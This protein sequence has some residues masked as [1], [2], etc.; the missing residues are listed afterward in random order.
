MTTLKMFFKTQTG[1]EWEE[2]ENGI[3][4]PP[5]TDSEGNVLPLHQGWY[6]LEMKGSM[7]TKWLMKPV[8]LQADVQ[9][10]GDGSASQEGRGIVLMEDSRSESSDEEQGSIYGYEDGDGEM[11]YDDDN[12]MSSNSAICDE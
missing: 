3:M 5:K 9:P 6:H 7:L 12:G 1:K 8:A 10:G 4:P 11:E 2:R